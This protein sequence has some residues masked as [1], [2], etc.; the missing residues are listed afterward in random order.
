AGATSMIACAK[1]ETT[2]I[3]KF[4]NTAETKVSYQ[5][6]A[7]SITKDNAITKEEKL[8]KYESMKPTDTLDVKFISEIKTTCKKKG[9][10]MT[11]NLANEKEAFI[12]FND[13]AFF[14]PKDG[15]ENHTAIVSGK[16]FIEETS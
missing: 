15:A 16:A 10:W 5:I 3:D 2:N 1:K 7:D 12:K 11:L 14:V 9:C 6:F 8:I 4:E 13:Y